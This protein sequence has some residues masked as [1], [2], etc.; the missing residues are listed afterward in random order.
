MET[1]RSLHDGSLPPVVSTLLTFALNLP[2]LCCLASRQ[3]QQ[4]TFSH[5]C[6]RLRCARVHK[7]N[8]KEIQTREFMNNRF[9]FDGSD[10]ISRAKD[11]M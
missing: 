10:F 9:G 2:L 4:H 3:E 5:A 1:L 7:P 11:T 6:Y 8:K